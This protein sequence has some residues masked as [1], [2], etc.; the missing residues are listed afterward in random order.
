M[1]DIL[2]V[3]H[4]DRI[5]EVHSEPPVVLGQYF[6]V[7]FGL[8]PHQQVGNI[9]ELFFFH[10]AEYFPDIALKVVVIDAYGHGGVLDGGIVEAHFVE[11]GGT[12]AVE[13]GSGF[14]VFEVLAAGECVLVVD[15]GGGEMFLFKCLVA[16]FLDFVDFFLPPLSLLNFYI[17]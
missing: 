12:V 13:D 9:V 3:V 4:A 1:E 5:A 14:G 2:P 6:G 7:C 8:Q 10:E 16:L 17:L 11:A 15:E